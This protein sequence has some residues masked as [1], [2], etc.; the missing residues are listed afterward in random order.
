MGVGEASGA[1]DTGGL[2]GFGEG[3]GRQDGGEPPSQ[4]RLARPWRTKKEDIMTA[5]RLSLC[6]HIE[7]K[8]VPIPLYRRGYNYLRLESRQEVDL[9]KLV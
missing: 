9:V 6:Y 8:I 2:K 1:V 3:H 5:F 7:D 4:H